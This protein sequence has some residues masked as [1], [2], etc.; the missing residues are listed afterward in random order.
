MIGDGPSTMEGLQSVSS[1]LLLSPFIF[2]T[3]CL[4]IAS[5]AKRESCK[6]YSFDAPGV[7]PCTFVRVHKNPIGTFA[8]S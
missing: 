2:F 6:S 1:E 5:V 4:E 3:F 7:A 8:F